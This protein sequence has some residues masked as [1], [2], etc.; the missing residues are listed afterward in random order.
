LLARLNKQLIDDERHRNTMSIEQLADRMS[1]CLEGEYEATIFSLADEV[2][3]Y[4]LYRREPEHIYIRQFLIVPQHRRHG[5]GRTA[6][7]WLRCHDWA[8]ADRLRVDVLVGNDAG[9]AFWRVVGFTDYCLT[10]EAEANG[11]ARSAE[12]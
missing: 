12:G 7:E 9:I 10:M 5:L 6:V 4:T 1:S 2:V 3:G 11:P 8:D